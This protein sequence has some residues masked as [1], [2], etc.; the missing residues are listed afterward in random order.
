MVLL[1]RRRHK[2]DVIADTQ[3]RVYVLDTAKGSPAWLTGIPKSSG[4]SSR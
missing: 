4:I 1:E 3:C 2:H